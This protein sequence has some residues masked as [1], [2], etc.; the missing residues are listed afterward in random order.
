MKFGFVAK[1]RGVWPLSSLPCNDCR[2]A[3]WHGCAKCWASPDPVF[4]HG[5]AE[6]RAPAHGRMK[7]SC[8]RSGRASP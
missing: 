8:R 4:M 7:H 5:S 1:H 6:G 2:A 3:G